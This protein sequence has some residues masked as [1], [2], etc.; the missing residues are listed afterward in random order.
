MISHMLS[1][2]LKGIHLGKFDSKNLQDKN[3]FE[4]KATNKFIH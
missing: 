2:L 3:D 1:Q 4:D